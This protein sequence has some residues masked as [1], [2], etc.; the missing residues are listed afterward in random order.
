MVPE[1][2]HAAGVGHGAGLVKKLSSHPQ[3]E[4]LVSDI[5]LYYYGHTVEKPVSVLHG[6][7]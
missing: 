7:K 5:S 3:L 4:H 1:S 6:S 2:G